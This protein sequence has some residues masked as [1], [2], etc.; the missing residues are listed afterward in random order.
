[1]KKKM[2][3][4]LLATL[5]LA[6]TVTAIGEDLN[7]EK[8]TSNQNIQQSNFE[9]QNQGLFSFLFSFVQPVGNDDQFEPG[10]TATFESDVEMTQDASTDSLVMITEFYRCYDS[11]CDDPVQDEF[12]EADRTFIDNE[13]TLSEGQTPTWEV[14]YTTP[15]QEDF[16]GAV[17]YVYDTDTGEKVSD[18]PTF[19][20]KL[21]NPE[22]P[23]SGDDSTDD[24]TNDETND[25]GT[26]EEPNIELAESPPSFT[27]GGITYGSYFSLSDIP[28]GTNVKSAVKL[29]NTGGDMQENYIIEMQVR[30]KSNPLSFVSSTSQTCDES[31][32]QNVH[33]E[34]RLDSGDETWITL[35]T[36]D[37]FEYGQPYNAYLVTRTGCYPNDDVGP[38]E[39]GDA[40]MKELGEFKSESDGTDD[41]SDDEQDGAT[42]SPKIVD[43]GQPT[44][45]YE[46]STGTVS[47]NVTFENIGGVNM[48]SE[49]IVEM[50]IRP[51]GEGVL[52]FSN[53]QSTCDPEHPENVHR[54]FQL[55][56]GEKASTTL[57]STL[58]LEPGTYDVHLVTRTECA[59]N[60]D[61]AEPYGY[62]ND[63][64]VGQ[65]VVEEP[66]SDGSGEEPG[67]VKPPTEKLPLL[68]IGL[69]LLVTSAAA[70]LVIIRG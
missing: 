27:Y 67:F 20:F 40:Y 28:D 24:G 21:G 25:G 14:E 3:V 30:E 17:S 47:T 55:D 65:V 1:M 49:N 8:A 4:A 42:D 38:F 23:D 15:E 2:I 33:K 39:Y 7:P 18:A 59:P 56:A 31:K 10:V 11:G 16:Y 34:F 43:V 66:P 51:E 35:E 61:E 13:F 41:S 69:G 54:S 12:L 68:S 45:S 46:S 58:N 29:R 22:S 6:S 19:E 37:I 62:G 63:E 52:S 53:T 9:V 60:N 48:Q 26:Q 44:L 50:Q 36:G 5:F 70:Y 64:L 57:S 32:P